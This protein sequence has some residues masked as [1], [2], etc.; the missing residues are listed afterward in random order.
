V[1]ACPRQDSEVRVRQAVGD[2][3][4]VLATQ[5]GTAL[6]EAVSESIVGSI[7]RNF[8]RDPG[9]AP[10]STDRHSISIVQY[11]PHMVSQVS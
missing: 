9:D 1:L 7:Q 11:Y 8:D 3:L 10:C 2:C 6:F 4:G 5:K